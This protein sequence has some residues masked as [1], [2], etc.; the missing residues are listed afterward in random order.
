MVGWVREGAI[1]VNFMRSPSCECAGRAFS[2]FSPP[3]AFS[4]ENGLSWFLVLYLSLPLSLLTSRAGQGRAEA[5]PKFRGKLSEGRIIN[6]IRCIP[7]RTRLH[8]RKDD[9]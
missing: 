9:S 4:L 2:G 8:G 6:E 5:I 1:V 3:L 7:D